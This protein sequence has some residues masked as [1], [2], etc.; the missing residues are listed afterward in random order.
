MI[1]SL[2]ILIVCIMFFTVRYNTLVNRLGVAYDTYTQIDYYFK[3]NNYK[4]IFDVGQP[5]KETGFTF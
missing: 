2:V 3:K 5:D 1:S 4:W